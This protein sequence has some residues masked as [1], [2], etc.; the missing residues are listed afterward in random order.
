MI[1]IGTN[2]FYT[3]TLPVTLWFLDNS[4]KGS[5][6][7]NQVLFIDARNLYRQIDRAHRDFLP[8]HIEFIANIVRLYRG[9]DVQNVDGSDELMATNFP[10]GAY[11]DVP[12]LCKI[13]TIDEIETQGWSLNPGRYT[14]TAVEDD[15]GV[16]FHEKLGELF[17]EFTQ[18]SDEAESLKAKVDAAVS[19]ILGIP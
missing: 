2:F 7:E 9:E 3:V 8:E 13:A 14:G 4:K 16:D 18:L 15:D 1:A 10:D 6:R 12:G 11:V 5:E 19:G 17:E